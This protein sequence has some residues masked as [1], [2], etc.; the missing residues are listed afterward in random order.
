[1][2]IGVRHCDRCG[3]PSP[4]DEAGTPTCPT[5]GSRWVH[6]RNAPCAAVVIQDDAGQILLARRAREPYAGMWET[7]GGFVELGEHPEDAA[8]REVR[9]ELG[10]EVTLTGLVGVYVEASAQGQHLLVLVYAGRATGEVRPDPAEVA[11]WAWFA[12]AD[13]PAVMAADHRR[14]VDDLLAGT[15]VPL[16]ARE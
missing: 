5:H 4:D 15:V 2:A 9:E 14:R 10:L 12:P 3:A 1:M 13:V 8:R 11:G 16:P 6:V 7:P